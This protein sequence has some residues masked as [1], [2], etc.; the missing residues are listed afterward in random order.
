MH[1]RVRGGAWHLL[2][3]AARIVRQFGI[4]FVSYFFLL[5]YRYNLRNANDMHLSPFTVSNTLGLASLRP[6]FSSTWVPFIYLA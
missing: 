4:A 1:R 2:A 6:S 5:S 3:A